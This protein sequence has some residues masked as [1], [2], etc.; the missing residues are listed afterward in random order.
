MLGIDGEPLL[1]L[2]KLMLQALRLDV[3]RHGGSNGLEGN[4]VVKQ[5]LVHEA[6][7]LYQGHLVFG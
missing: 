3:C 5:G 2:L 4:R 7:T 1:S 6:K